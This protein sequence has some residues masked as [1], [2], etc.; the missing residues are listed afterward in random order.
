MKFYFDFSALGPALCVVQLI[1]ANVDIIIGKDIV[2]LGP[3]LLEEIVSRF[4][5]RIR[6]I[7]GARKWGLKNR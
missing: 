4:A 6:R 5:H 3:E 1:A 7:I 2:N